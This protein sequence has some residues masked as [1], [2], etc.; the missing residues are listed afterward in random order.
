M[1]LKITDHPITEYVRVFPEYNEATKEQQLLCLQNMESWIV[2]E[3]KR[4]GPPTGGK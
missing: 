1:E 2:G 3:R 4:L